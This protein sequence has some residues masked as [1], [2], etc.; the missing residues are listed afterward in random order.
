MSLDNL[1]TTHKTKPVEASQDEH[2]NVPQ[3]F[4]PTYSSRLN[5]VELWFSKVQRDVLSP[6]IF[7]SPR[8]LRRYIDAYSKRAM[9]FRCKYANPA[10]RIAHGEPSSRTVHY[11]LRIVIA[12]PP[13][14]TVPPTRSRQGFQALAPAA[15]PAWFPD[16]DASPMS[17]P[18]DAAGSVARHLRPK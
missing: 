4:T 14:P 1:S 17:V 13:R 18:V 15:R 10:Q 2:P 8:T 12:L 11:V 7:T 5:H 6:G 3:H 9:P 16:T